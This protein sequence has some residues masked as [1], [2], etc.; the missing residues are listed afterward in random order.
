MGHGGF[1]PRA[2]SGDRTGSSIRHYRSGADAHRGGEQFVRPNPRREV[3][4]PRD[5]DELVE[6]Q[7]S[8]ERIE[9][10]GDLC[11]VGATEMVL[12]KWYH[13]VGVHDHPHLKLYVNGKH[14][15]TTTFDTAWKSDDHAVGIGNQSQFPER[16][17]QWDGLLDEARVLS[18]PKDEHWIKL[19]YES[20]KED[21][22]F[23][24]FGP[25]QQRQ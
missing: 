19:D 7:L 13:F 11:D 9:P 6:R 3:V 1:S 24:T 8:R 16:G 14:D 20:Q 5:D 22:R 15:K 23:L 10:R 21:Q 25:P 12:D 4:G 18:V 2:R 17:R